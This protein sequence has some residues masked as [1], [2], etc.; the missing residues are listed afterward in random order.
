MDIFLTMLEERLAGDDFNFVLLMGPFANLP[1]VE[2][3]KRLEAAR[4]NVRVL[5]FTSNAIGLFD[6]SRLVISMG[7]YNSVCELLHLRKY[8]L[9]LPRVTPREEQLIRAK[10]FKAR[11][12]MDYIHPLDLSPISLAKKVRELSDFDRSNVP[13][14][15]TNGIENVSNFIEET[16]GCRPKLGSFLKVIHA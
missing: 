10:V 1:L 9:I 2:R 16:L 14:F 7:G 12:L 4:A 8:P 13:A 6:R 11:G 15:E 5:G 3:A